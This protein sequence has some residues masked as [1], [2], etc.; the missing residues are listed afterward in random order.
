M[1]LREPLELPEGTPVQTLKEPVCVGAEH[2]RH[3][4]WRSKGGK[5]WTCS[6]CFGNPFDAGDVDWGVYRG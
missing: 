5:H 3:P 4:A 6:G 1:P 2:A